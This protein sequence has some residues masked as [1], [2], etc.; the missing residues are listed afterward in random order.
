MAR[1]AEAD[2]APLRVFN[3]TYQADEID[4]FLEEACTAGTTDIFSYD[5]YSYSNS[6]FT[7]MLKFR[8]AA[9][10]CGIPYW[11]YLFAF[12][13]DGSRDEVPSASDLR[14]DAFSGLLAGYTG[15]TW[16]LY[17]VEGDDEG[18]PTVFF[19]TANRWDATITEA[20]GH[21]AAINRE[22]VAYGRAQSRLRSTAVGWYT[23]RAIPTLHPPDDFPQ[24]RAGMGGDRFLQRIE[25]SGSTIQ[26][27]LLG[28]FEDRYRET[29]VIVMNPNH[30]LGSFP[31]SGSADARVTLRF[32][33]SGASVAHDHLQVLRANGTVENVPLSANAVTFDIPPG[34][35]VF[36]KYDSGHGFEGYR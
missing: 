1:I 17:N 8:A 7:T 13:P 15:H 36:Y 27:V 9:Q 12:L 22:L 16:F 10:R 30:P 20:F 26:D 29:Y 32:D 34:D 28:F 2:P 19:D 35:I 6:Q 23:A 33:F 11:R 14:W 5:R 3:F 18:I 21:A 24:W 31:T 4:A 25:A